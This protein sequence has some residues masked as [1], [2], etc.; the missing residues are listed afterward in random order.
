MSNTTKKIISIFATLFLFIFGSFAAGTKRVSATKTRGCTQIVVVNNSSD[1]VRIAQSDGVNVT[2]WIKSGQRSTF[3]VNSIVL[4][5]GSNCNTSSSVSGRNFVITVTGE[6]SNNNSGSVRN[7]SSS[8][9]SKRV[10]E[11]VPCHGS[12]KCPKCNGKG[13][14]YYNNWGKKGDH[15]KERC[16]RCNGN[17]VCIYCRGSGRK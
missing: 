14:V 9:S 10:V 17:G 16:S 5:I 1:T 12:G 13:W 3:S 2:G 8:S 11:C 7:S 15:G 4:E 6:S